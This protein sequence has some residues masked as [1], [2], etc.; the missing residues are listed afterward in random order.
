ML[1]W[2]DRS[3]LPQVVNP[4][5]PVTGDKGDVTLT[6]EATDSEQLDSLTK[7]QQHL[8]KRLDDF[9]SKF[10]EIMSQMG[11]LDALTSL[12]TKMSE[13]TKKVDDYHDSLTYTQAKIV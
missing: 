2:R 1:I 3:V 9:S 4:P 10:E 13:L 6:A 11:K 8:D 12:D 7:Y 5:T